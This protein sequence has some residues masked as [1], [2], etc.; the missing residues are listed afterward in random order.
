MI[1]TSFTPVVG[2]AV[3]FANLLLYIMYKTQIPLVRPSLTQYSIPLLLLAPVLI[4]IASIVMALIAWYREEKS[5]RMIKKRGIFGMIWTIGAFYL[6]MIT[7]QSFLIWA[8]ISGLIGIRK[9]FR[10]TQKMKLKTLGT[11]N[12]KLKYSLWSLGLFGLAILFMIAS[13]QTF[14]AENPLF[15][16]F[17]MAAVS[18]TMPIIITITYFPKLELLRT[19][20]ATK[21]A[22]DVE[23]EHQLKEMQ[24][25][26][27]TRQEKK[28]VKFFALT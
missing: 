21:S 13:Y 5:D 18:L 4:S 22:A 24:Q 28:G 11:K 15:G 6:L 25:K 3:W 14:I 19:F 12:E 23:R 26:K 17:I 7:A 16:W 8:V 2:I 1:N 9:E 27:K 10:R 20:A